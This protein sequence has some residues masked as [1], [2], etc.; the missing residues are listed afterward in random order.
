MRPYNFK[1]IEARR[2][3]YWDQ[4]GTFKAGPAGAK[5]KYYCLVMFPY[6]SGELHV[7]HGR[8]YILGDS[9]MRWKVKEGYN[10]MFPIGW[11]AFGLPA[12]NAAIERNLHPRAWTEANIKRMRQQ[13]RAWGIAFD[14]SR[15]VAACDPDYYKWTQ[16]IFVWMYRRGLAYRKEAAVNWCPCCQTVLAN[17]QVVAGLCERCDTT[18]TVTRLE[19]WFF[20]ITDYAD[21]LLQDLGSLEGWPERVKT[22]QRNWIG[23]SEGVDINFRLEDGRPL[24]CFTTRVDTIFGV[25]YAVLSPDH[26]DLESILEGSPVKAE[27]LAFARECKLKAAQ[28]KF[29]DTEKNGFFTGKR[30]VNPVNNERIPLWIADYVVGDYGTGAIMAVPAHDQRDFEFARKYGLPMRLVISPDGVAKDAAAL[31]MAYI[32]DGIEVNSGQFDGV[33]NRLA[34]EKIADYMTAKGMGKRRVRYRLRDWLISRQRYWGAPI[35]I[36]YCKRCGTVP[37]P[38]QDLPV[39]LPTIDKFKPTGQSPLTY[40]KEFVET[41]CPTCGGPARRETDTMDTFVDSSWYY[42]RYLTPDDKTRPFSADEVNY[43]LPVDMYI[44]GIEHAILHLMYSRFVTKVLADMGQMEAREP[45]ANLFTQG[46]IWKD[47]AKMSKSKGNTVSA[48]GVIDQYG[49]DTARLATLFLGPPEKDVEWVN[50]GVEGSYRFLTRFWRIV[51]AVSEFKVGGAPPPPASLDAADLAVLRKAHW[52]VKKIRE[53]IGVRFHF[54]TAISAAMELVNEMSSRMSERA[55]TEPR[56]EAQ[57]VL[58][59]AAEVCLHT[60]SP[61]IPHVCEELWANLGHRESIF[62]VPF[63]DY[64]EGLLKTDTVNVVVQVNGKVRA[65]ISVAAG[66]TEQEVQSASLGQ[67]A[68]AKWLDGRTLRKT[69]YVKDKL[70]NLVVA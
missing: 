33:P 5:P 21:Q 46:M 10:V 58:R 32:E 66:A 48:D 19:Q 20:R 63:P 30:L 31:E 56:P 17:E 47:G 34:M 13:L 25:T 7:G 57:R 9:L 14:W 18:V 6:P 60:L 40:V 8:N 22:M 23:R 67:P 35:P 62:E 12:E 36:I 69:I 16:L 50:K 38:E 4:R 29:T 59:F 15:E 53:D 44:G 64:D 68:V 45:F 3:A 49:A 26:P 54:N 70:I 24:R 55:E 43:W 52:A 11:D 39:L 27:A 1:E 65:T 2:Q 37:V 28:R 51:D 42:L 41:T 61:M